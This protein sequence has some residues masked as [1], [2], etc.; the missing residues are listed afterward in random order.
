MASDADNISRGIRVIR[1]ANVAF[2]GKT[3]PELFGLANFL[4]GMSAAEDCPE[5]KT[6]LAEASKWIGKLADHV[7]RQGYIGC[8]GGRD[9][10]SDHK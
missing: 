5:A 4:A 7:C 6:K 3:H 8:H 1:S 10:T 2:Y 9:C